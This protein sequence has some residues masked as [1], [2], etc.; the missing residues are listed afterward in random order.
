M[1]K[2]MKILTSVWV[3][4]LAAVS[5]SYGQA[6]PAG[7]TTISS[8]GSNPNVPPLDGILHY[9][10]TASQ[11]VQFGYY[12]SGETTS[13]TGLSGNLSF[14]AKSETKPF[15]TT[16]SGGLLL[17]N[18]QG[19]GI[20]TF[21]NVGVT[22]GIVGR[23]WAATVSDSFSFLPQSPTT[24]LSGIP[25]VGDLGAD[26][27]Q[28]PVAGPGGG[29]L[30]YS[31]DRI[32]NSLSGSVERQ[33]APATSISGSGSWSIIHFLDQNAGLNSSGVS[34]DVALNQRLDGRSSVSLSGFYSTYSYS[35]PTAGPDTPDFQTK[36]INLGYQRRLNRSL[37]MS[38]SGGPLWISS[39]DSALFPSR[40]TVGAS[41][42]LSYTHGLTNANVSYNRGANAGSGVIPGSIS[43]IVLGSV[44]RTF[45][46]KWVASADGGYSH[47]NGLA[48]YTMGTTLV[49][50][51]EIY[52]TTFGGVQ[53]TRGFGAHYSTY[54]SFTV[55]HQTGNYAAAGLNA[56]NGT[57]EVF[58][59]GITFTPRS[60]RLGQ[61]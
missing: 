9:S 39:S 38:V 21:W 23:R 15:S 18:G 52:N 35:G 10:M 50:V 14:T 41:A 19:Q 5:L 43:D 22:Q 4:S 57:S 30:T 7:N 20:S 55:L 61:F 32:F 2:I 8:T 40:L 59:V 13:S 27:V 11:Q 53:V 54:A 26:P 46:R 16:L 31:G 44:A 45:G 36:G 60:T 33:I 42:T 49:G 25:G 12:G 24:G 37:S 1:K 34:G 3:L 48:E 29:V 6:V 28:G 17:P 58:A 47:A 56:F 51:N